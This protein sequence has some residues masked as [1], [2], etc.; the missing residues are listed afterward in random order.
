MGTSIGGS[1]TYFAMDG[2]YGDS[3]GMVTIDTSTW[4]Q[5]DWDRIE[6]ASDYDRIVVALNIAMGE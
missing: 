4:S 5:E 2:N 6:M 3:H 1:V